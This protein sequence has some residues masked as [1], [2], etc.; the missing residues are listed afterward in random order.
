MINFHEI[1]N[2]SLTKDSCHDNK[3][4]N[5]LVLG[6]NYLGFLQSEDSML[7]TAT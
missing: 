1:I 4:D 7:P 2:L 3:N 5:K 6:N